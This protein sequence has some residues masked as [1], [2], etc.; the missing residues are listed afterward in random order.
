MI[1]HLPQ[2]CI[3]S[4]PIPAA[5]PW[6]T[7][8]DYFHWSLRVCLCIDWEREGGVHSDHSRETDVT[9]LQRVS[10]VQ[11]SLIRFITAA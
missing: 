3:S 7:I 8:V 1:L 9:L 10:V 2:L 6:G 5:Q 4:D 11:H